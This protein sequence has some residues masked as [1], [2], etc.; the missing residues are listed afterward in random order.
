[1]IKARRGIHDNII[2]ILFISIVMVFAGELVWDILVPDIDRKNAYLYTFMRYAQFISMWI[3]VFFTVTF[4]KK[5]RYIIGFI[6]TKT[7]ANNIYNL[8]LGFLFGFILNISSAIVAFLHGDISL[9]FIKFELLHVTWL[10][11]AVFIQSSAEELLCRGFM[12]QRF[13]KSV[14]NPAIAIFLNS[15]LFATLHLF[16][17]GMSALAFYDLLVTGIFF[18]LIVFY[19]DSLWMAM[20]VHTTWN[21]TQSILLGLPNSGTSFPYSVFKLDTL[22]VYGS[23]AYNIEFG[24]EGTILSSVIMTACCIGLY[25]WKN[26]SRNIF[27]N[28]N[29]FTISDNKIKEV[30]NEVSRYEN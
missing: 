23:F 22:N 28:Y 8:L 19:F 15:F 9:I 1:M 26:K 11:I 17:E 2:W 20:G 24:L 12:Y 14:S 10:F 25:L 3:S 7:K 29:Y 16:N 21:F 13:L 5:N 27:E 30:T 4:F 6:T 18:S